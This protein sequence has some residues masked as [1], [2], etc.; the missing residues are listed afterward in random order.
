MSQSAFILSSLVVTV[1]CLSP[2]E[3][4]VPWFPAR[5][6]VD[7]KSAAVR[8]PPLV[9]AWA[10]QDTCRCSLSTG[11]T[12]A[13]VLRVTQLLRC[14]LSTLPGRTHS[15]TCSCQSRK[16]HLLRHLWKKKSKET[17]CSVLGHGAIGG[18]ISTYM[19][20]IFSV[21]TQKCQDTER[22]LGLPVP[23]FPA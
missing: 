14:S 2:D 4:V 23:L 10:T 18:D 17:G 19:R 5:A 7:E 15:N 16:L 20:S 3:A 11:S 1:A 22:Q 8:L 21:M 12:L 9:C 13:S 6:V